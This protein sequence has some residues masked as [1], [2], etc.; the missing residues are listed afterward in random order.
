MML[1]NEK[2]KEQ[3][4]IDS[5]DKVLLALKQ[6]KSSKSKKYTHIIVDDSQ[7]LTKV[8]LDF[9]NI[10]SSKNSYASLMFIV[11]KDRQLNPNG[12]IIKGRKVNSLE[13]GGKIKNYSLKKK[14]IDTI[15]NEDCISN[16]EDLKRIVLMKGLRI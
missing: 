5:K 7:N 13:L 14:Y 6:V 9:I 4:L 8:Q 10:L 3:K 11:N 1:Y 12:W 2:L 15:E 16:A